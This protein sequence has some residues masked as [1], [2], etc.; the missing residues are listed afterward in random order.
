MKFLL[1]IISL[2]LL[3]IFIELIDAWIYLYS[4][5]ILLLWVTLPLYLTVNLLKENEDER[6]YN[7]SFKSY[8][9]KTNQ[10]KP[11]SILNRIGLGI[12]GFLFF[13]IDGISFFNDCI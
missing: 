3:L 10:I 7:S 9:I 12:F 11:L 2:L 1:S 8:L 5:F 4:I 13:F 6:N